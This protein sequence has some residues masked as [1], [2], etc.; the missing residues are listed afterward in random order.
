[1]PEVCGVSDARRLIGYA[2]VST[3]E[4]SLDLQL[5]ALKTAGCERVFKEKAS[6]TRSTLPVLETCLETLEAGDVLVVWKL[7]RFGRSL[8]DLILK[9]H[10]LGER[11]IG[12]QALQEQLDTTTPAGRL[13]F[14]VVA[15]LAEFESDLISE[16]TKAGLKAARARGS[17]P[18]RPKVVTPDRLSVAEELLKLEEDGAQ[19]HSVSDVAGILGVSPSSLYRALREPAV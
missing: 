16:R 18:G 14:H 9:T 4:Q 8:K 11:G 13:F 12:F 6:A 5:D 10:A 19:K 15:A 2:R 1:M 7:D 17:V 3:G